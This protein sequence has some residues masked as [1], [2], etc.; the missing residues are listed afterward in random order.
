MPILPTLLARWL[1]SQCFW[2]GTL[3]GAD[4][5]LADIALSWLLKAAHDMQCSDVGAGPQTQSPAAGAS[6]GAGESA[7]GTAPRGRQ[8]NRLIRKDERPPQGDWNHRAAS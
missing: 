2:I 7:R 6:R 5:I 4:G 8:S 3:A 1:P